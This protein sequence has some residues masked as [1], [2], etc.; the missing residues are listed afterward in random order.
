MK[1]V[2]KFSNGSDFLSIKFTDSYKKEKKCYDHHFGS[3]YFS[4]IKLTQNDRKISANSE[5]RKL[6]REKDKNFH[7]YAHVTK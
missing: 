7:T 1:Y 4:V 6:N 5:N 2:L 3:R